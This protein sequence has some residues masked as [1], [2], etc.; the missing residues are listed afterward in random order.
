[1][2]NT[3]KVFSKP[4]SKQFE[5]DEDVASV[6]DDMLNRSVPYYKESL[7]LSIKFAKK[8]LDDGD[9]VY[10]LGCST[11]ATLLSLKKQ[12]PELNLKLIGVDNSEAMLKQAEQ[13][14]KLLGAQIEFIN[15]DILN[16]DNIITNKP[17]V[18]FSNYTIQFIR[19]LVRERLIKQIYNSLDDGGV[20][21]FSEKIISK[22]STLNK[23]LIDEY[24][25]FK[26]TKGYSEYEISQKREALENI[27]IP[28]SDEENITMIKNCGFKSC[29][30]LLKWINFSTFI[31]IK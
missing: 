17:K 6:F 2:D 30:I 22:N 1:L 14:N 12:T 15:D 19:P 16:I 3:D 5:F 9:T 31:A 24:Y 11:A 27:L 26:K 20:F 4:I 29:D 8:F 13:K 10:D 21:I 28:Y 25:E 18:I 7:E 23:H